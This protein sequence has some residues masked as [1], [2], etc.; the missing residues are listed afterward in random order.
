MFFRKQ[1]TAVNDNR[2]EPAPGAQA[3]AATVIA[4]GT[5]VSGNLECE[6]ELRVEGTVLGSVRAETLLLGPDGV[7]EGDVI[8][9]A[10]RV[11]GLV[12]GPLRARHVHLMADATVEGDIA[13]ATI[14][15]ETGAR[16]TGAVWQE[17]EAEERDWSIAPDD[18]F[19]PLAVA[20]PRAGLFGR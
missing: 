11:A 12:R 5:R 3:D 1:K 4:R 13:S 15:I 19:R 18:G 6:G 8:A 7:I 9:E 20:R 2:A 10:V 17:Q 16:L 14:A